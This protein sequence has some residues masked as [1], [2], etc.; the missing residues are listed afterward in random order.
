MPS[1]RPA[2]PGAARTTRRPIPSSIT[3]RSAAR[4]QRHD[5]PSLWATGGAPGTA[6]ALCARYGV[7]PRILDPKEIQQVLPARGAL[8]SPEGI[9]ELE[10]ATLTSGKKVKEF[11]EGMMA[12]SRAY[13]RSRKE[14]VYQATQDGPSAALGRSGPPCGVP[15]VRFTRPIARRLVS[16]P[17]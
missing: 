6:A 9:A 12:D 13:W 3:A 15:R 1:W 11:Y 2:R 8:V 4:H 10:W 5:I 14:R 7:Q 16:G 17:F